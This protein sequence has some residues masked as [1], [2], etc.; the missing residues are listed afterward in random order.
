V[1]HARQDLALTHGMAKLLH[2]INIYARHTTGYE[3]D[4]KRKKRRKRQRGERKRREK[5]KGRER[6]NKY[7]H[8]T[9]SVRCSNV[10]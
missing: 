5:E 10:L 9:H 3:K 4:R 1:G 8:H 2:V 7:V 6:K